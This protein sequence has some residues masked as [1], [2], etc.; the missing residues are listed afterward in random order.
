MAGPI[1]TA[2]QALTAPATDGTPPRSGR[3]RILIT[4]LKWVISLLLIGWILRSTELGAIGAALYSAVP[5]WVLLAAALHITGFLIAAY[6]WQLLLHTQGAHASIPFLME[7]YIVSIFFSNFLPSTIGGDAVR[8]YDTW[9]IGGSKSEAVAIIF[10]DRFLGLFV[11]ML[12]ALA[13]LPLTGALTAALPLLHLWVVLGVAGMAVITWAIFMPSRFFDLLTKLPLPF[14]RKVKQVFTAFL[15]FQGRR[16]VLLKQL[17][18]SLL[19]QANVVIH[20]YFI[21]RALHLDVPLY[22]FFF[23]IPLV[24]LLM[25]LPISI[26]AIGIRESAFGFFLAAYGVTTADA[27]AFAWIA[28]GPILLQGILGGLIYAL[29][30]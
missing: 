13:A 6:R 12:F 23:I 22:S 14:P 1:V 21:A 29:R 11:L 4:G 24:T 19:L 8:A 3:K 25:M 16:D 7:S 18:L 30:R 2:D 15:P 17:W 27:V 26:N 5:S 10:V 20:Y 28:Y 9:R